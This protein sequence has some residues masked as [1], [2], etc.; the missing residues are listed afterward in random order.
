[1]FY[2]IW[3]NPLLKYILKRA[4]LWCLCLINYDFIKHLYI[5]HAYKQIYLLVKAQEGGQILHLPKNI[6][7][8]FLLENWQELNEDLSMP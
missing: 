8:L 7:L 6:E 2:A 4:L 5:H 1:M 3:A